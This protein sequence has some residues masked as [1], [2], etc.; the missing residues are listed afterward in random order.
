MDWPRGALRPT[1]VCLAYLPHLGVGASGGEE[2]EGRQEDGGGLAS[3]S[4]L[5]GAREGLCLSAWLHGRRL[6]FGI[7]SVMGPR[8]QSSWLTAPRPW[9]RG[10]GW[11]GWVGSALSGLWPAGQSTAHELPPPS[12]GGPPASCTQGWAP[13]CIPGGG[14]GK[15]S[16]DCCWLSSLE[17]QVSPPRP[18]LGG[19]VPFWAGLLPWVGAGGV[20]LCP[21][22][23]QSSDLQAQQGRLPHPDKASAAPGQPPLPL[24]CNVQQDT[25]PPCASVSPSVNEGRAGSP[26][27]QDDTG[28]RTS[29]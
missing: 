8:A 24:L 10:A 27:G 28:K 2:G 25:W 5:P 9:R 18:C 22:Q 11:G 1:S 16:P 21:P 14:G 15:A 29:E 20:Q 3:A 13:P 17:P 26:C 7:W 19:R 4:S 6:C 23:P 12:L